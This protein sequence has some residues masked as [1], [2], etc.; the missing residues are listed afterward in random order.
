MK[1]KHIP[2]NKPSAIKNELLYIKK[3]IKSINH[4][5]S[6]YFNNICNQFLEDKIGTKKAFL[7]PSCT[8]S[9]EMS[10]LLI[11]IKADDE[12]IMPSFTFVSTANAF[13]L[14]GAIPI[15]VDIREDTLNI[16][17]NLI[18]AAITSKTKAIVVVHYA[19]VSCEMEA[20]LKIAKKYKLFVI[21][22]A[23]QGFGAFYKNK[24]LGSMGDIGAHSFHET[25]NINCGEG[26]SI[27][28]NN[29]ELIAKAEI[30]REKGTDRKKFFR[31]E[32]DKYTWKNIGSSFLL[33]EISA[34]YLL[35]QLENENLI[36]KNRLNAWNYYNKK[37][38]NLESLGFLKR[39]VIPKNCKHNAHIYYCILS[40]KMNRKTL[41][42]YLAS[43]NINAVSHYTPLHSSSAG[44]KFARISSKLNITNKISSQII[45]L[46][47]WY[48][49]TK[50]EQ[51]R[52]IFYLEEY[53]N[54]K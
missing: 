16:N 47:L 29:K 51:D 19:G 20:I 54:K 18:E 32:V 39:P 12:I 44:K 46:P 48:K 31:G 4:S 23:A 42:N 13:V 45:R 25:K 27:L 33:N 43:K 34:A 38:T 28:I 3:A 6:G 1:S 10:S 49:I 8:A 7:T 2:F 35:N 37:L 21:E 24:A 14:R 41:L 40:K 26:G 15:F 11:N 30:I 17:E 22:D 9:L 52:V 50:K 5:G 53:C 36:T